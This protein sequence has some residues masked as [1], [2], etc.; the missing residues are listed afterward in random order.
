M[1]LHRPHEEHSWAGKLTFWNLH[2]QINHSMFTN[3]DL[4]TNKRSHRCSGQ[5]GT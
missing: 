3:W 2:R 4:L 1:T 5:V